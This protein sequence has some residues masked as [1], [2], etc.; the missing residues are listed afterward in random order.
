MESY[1]S[2]QA[3]IRCSAAQIYAVLSNFNNFTPML[4]DKVENWQA[5]ENRCS[6]TF[7]GFTVALRIVDKEPGKVIKI[8]GDGAMPVDFTFWLQMKELAPDDTRIRLVLHTELNMMM[9]MMIGGKIQK[10]LDEMVD[11]IARTF[12]TV[13]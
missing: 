8:T 1:E 11:Q 7:K 10:G 9:K 6:F 12:N 5:E 13:F 4:K 3:A 2:K